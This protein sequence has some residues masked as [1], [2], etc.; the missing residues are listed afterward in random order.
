M[1]FESLLEKMKERP[2]FEAE[3]LLSGSEN[4]GAIRVQIARWAKAK[5]IIQLRRGVYLLT[6]TYRKIPLFEPALAAL[7]QKPS[8]ISLEKALE[9]HGLIPEA[10]PVFTSVTTKR[11]ERLKTP[12]GVF[13]YRHIQPSLFWGYEAVTM[14]RQTA[15]VAGPEKA[16]LDFFYLKEKKMTLHS[17][18]ELRLQNLKKINLKK[19]TE[20]A[21]RF[22]KKRM[23]NAA[24]LLKQYILKN[25][26]R[27]R[28]V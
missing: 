24:E 28:P 9:Y 6:E 10:V 15:F 26:R 22:D 3:T 7:L 19:L 2:V 14:N 25:V 5:K 11:P 16:V 12:A 21:E 27:E 13:D 1:K 17:L 20:S 8:Y 4:P 18:E 23:T